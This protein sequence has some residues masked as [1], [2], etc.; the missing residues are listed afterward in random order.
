MFIWWK[1]KITQTTIDA[2]NARAVAYYRHSAQDRQENSISL[3]QEQVRSWASEHGIEIIKEFADHGKS[4]LSTADRDAF[5]DMIE[6]WV[7]RRQDF[8]YILLLDVSRWGRF[9]DTDISAVHSAE[10]TKHGKQVIYTTIG[11]PKKDDPL[12]SVYVTF[13]RFRAAQYSR[14]LSDK[15]FKGCLKIAQQ[16]YRAGGPPPYA[17]KRLLVNESRNPIQVLNPG[18]RKSIQNQRVTL[19]P[20][21]EAEIAVVRRIF[22]SF[23]A[24]IGE[25]KI[26]QS[27]NFDRIPSPG[28][29]NWDSSKVGNILRNEVYSGTIIYNKKTKRLLSPTRSNP[30]DH[31]IRTHNA[32]KGIIPPEIFEKAQV[33]LAERTRRST[34]ENMLIR[35]KSHYHEYGFVQRGFIEADRLAPSFRAYTRCFGRL[36]RAFLATFSDVLCRVRQNIRHQLTSLGLLLEEWDDFIVLNN[37]LTVSIQPS[38]PIP[39]GCRTYW[40]FE[41]D[42]RIEVDIT[43]GVPLSNGDNFDILGFLALPRLIVRS[44]FVRLYGASDTKVDLFGHNGLNVLKDILQ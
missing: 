38:V 20:G 32:F 43:L 34:R 7:K 9:Q 17:F 30:I 39:N 33:Q 1:R 3:Q 27:L 42:R 44:K 10:C 19:T 13:E 18:E 6:N 26:A 24:G 25:D 40:S 23:V 11:I 5:I 8:E 36:D 12:Y 41:I 14:E 31:W 35:L 28:G 37:S 22:Q 4:G 2:R 21:N 29:V 16:G 15:V